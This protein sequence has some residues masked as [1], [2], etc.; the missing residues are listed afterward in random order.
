M[1]ECWCTH[2]VVAAKLFYPDRFQDI[3]LVKE[4]QDFYKKFYD[5]DLSA[6][7]VQRIIDAEAPAK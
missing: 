4:T 2:W 6:D 5:Y 3:D 1:F 7:E